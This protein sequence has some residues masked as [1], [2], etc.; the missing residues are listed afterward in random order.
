VSIAYQIVGDGPI[1]LVFVP[2]FVSHLDLQWGV[3]EWAA[4][5]ERL[6]SFSRVIIFDKRGTGLSDPVFAVPTLEER[7]DDVA[8]VMDASRSERAAFFGYSEGGMMSLLFA[9][10]HPE[11]TLA[12]VL[13]G[14]YAQRAD[15]NSALRPSWERLRACLE[16]WGEGTTLEVFAPSIAGGEIQRRLRGFVERAAASPAMALRL[17]ECLETMD[18]SA[19]LPTIRV[20]TL[21]LHRADDF[22]PFEA[23][24]YIADHVPGARLVELPGVDHMPWVGDAESVL[25]EME[26]FLTGSRH[27]ARSERLLTTVLFTDLVGST[28]TVVRLGDAKWRDLREAHDRIVREQLERFG[29]TFI[30]SA[31]DGVFATFDGPVR[32]IS[33]ARAIADAVELLGLKVRAGVHSGEVQMGTKPSGLA[34]H[35]GARIVAKASPGEILV[36]DAVRGLSAGSG[37]AYA[38]RGAYELKGLPGMWRLFA[39][40][41]R[42]E[43]F[44]VDP[45]RRLG[46]IDRTLTAVSRRAPALLRAVVSLTR[47]TG[48]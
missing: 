43:E 48:R 2:G 39:V 42:L 7:M 28:E 8:A 11:R 34:V 10:T 6:A 46:S 25:G 26:Q 27:E 32:A 13:C 18:V 47:M 5:V 41:D 1:D 17:I 45:D 33:C 38:D 14:A 3:P 30:D 40:L 24:R 44:H 9:A 15:P 21:V 37:M 20:P 16:T 12:L 4:F 23:G 31:G 29:G 22:I 35:I 36:S 19:V